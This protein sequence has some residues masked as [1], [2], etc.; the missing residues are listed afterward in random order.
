MS[1]AWES[2]HHAALEFAA[3]DTIKQR[4]IKA[5]SSHLEEMDLENLP[6]DL[7]TEFRRLT[8]RLTA[9]RPSRGETAVIATVR[10]MSNEDA[11]SC[12]QQILELMVNLAEQRG[13]STPAR[14]RQV[15]SLYSAEG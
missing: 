13:R 15:L 14:T 11:S 4:L 3:A 7:R 12:A 9:V 5:F 1:A 10:K 2:L 6:P 8:D